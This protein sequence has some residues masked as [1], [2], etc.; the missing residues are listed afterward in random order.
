[1]RNDLIIGRL[2][3]QGKLLIDP[4]LGSGGFYK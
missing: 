4:F 2:P 3:C 1:M